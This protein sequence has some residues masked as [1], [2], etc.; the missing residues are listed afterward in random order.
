MSIDRLALS[1]SIKY[2]MNTCKYDPEHNCNLIASIAQKILKHYGIESELIGG[3]SAWRVNTFDDNAVYAGNYYRHPYKSNDFRLFGNFWLEVDD[4][5]VDFSMFWLPN[6]FITLDRINMRRTV[7]DWCP[8]YLW[9]PKSELL[10]IHQLRYAN[11]IGGY[12]ERDDTFFRRIELVSK[13]INL[14]E[15]DYNVPVVQPLL[16]DMVLK[17]YKLLVESGENAEVI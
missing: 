4:N 8:P 11:K 3:Y 1:S 13:M 14:T 7:I 5:I 16:F 12:Y 2:I 15:K 10:T 17:S 9:I 6:K